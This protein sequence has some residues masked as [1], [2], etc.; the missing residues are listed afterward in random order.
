MRRHMALVQCSLLVV[1][2]TTS[3]ALGVDYTRD[4]TIELATPQVGNTST[5]FG[6]ETLM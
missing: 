2:L 4:G 1:C 3:V 5:P 6:G